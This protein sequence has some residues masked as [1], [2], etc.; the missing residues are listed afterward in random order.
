MGGAKA[1]GPL[2]TPLHVIITNDEEIQNKIK[3]KVLV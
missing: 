3:I 1:Q 2:N